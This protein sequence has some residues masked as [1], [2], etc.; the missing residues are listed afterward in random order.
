MVGYSVKN[1]SIKK[2]TRIK[3][4]GKCNGNSSRR[5]M[6]NVNI[7]TVKNILNFFNGFEPV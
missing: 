7:P 4:W 2:Y 1:I 6:K 5:E 3:L